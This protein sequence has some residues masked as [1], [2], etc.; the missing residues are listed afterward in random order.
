MLYWSQSYFI[1]IILLILLVSSLIYDESKTFANATLGY[2]YWRTEYFTTFFFEWFW[3]YIT[4]LT[5]MYR[6]RWENLLTLI[7]TFP[8]LT[9]MIYSAL[10][11]NVFFYITLSIGGKVKNSPLHMLNV[12]DSLFTMPFVVAYKSSRISRKKWK[13][14]LPFQED[15]KFMIWL[16]YQNCDSAWIVRGNCA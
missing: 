13:S 2:A 15:F 12:E 10:S 6:H 9:G 14:S 11:Q 7:Q 8:D 5:G 4:P 16:K 1:S 3:R